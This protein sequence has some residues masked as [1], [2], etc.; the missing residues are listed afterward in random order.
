M[1]IMWRIAQYEVQLDGVDH[2][3]GMQVGE[4]VSENLTPEEM[5]SHFALWAIAKSPLMISAD[6]RCPHHSHH[7]HITALRHTYSKASQKS[8][9]LGMKRCQP[10]V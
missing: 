1:Y 8:G 2:W 4:P 5:Q 7:I 3:Y 6:L 9:H 10:W